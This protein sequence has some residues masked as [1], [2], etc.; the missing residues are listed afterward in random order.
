MLGV[1]TLGQHRIPIRSCRLDDGLRGERSIS[2][3]YTVLTDFSVAV[4]RLRVPYPLPSEFVTCQ[5]PPPGSGMSIDAGATNVV[6]AEIPC[7]RA[8]TKAN[9]LKADPV[10]LPDPP[11]PVARFTR[12]AASFAQYVR[13]PSTDHR[14]DVAGSR[15]EDGHGCIGIARIREDAR[16]R[17]LR[18][19]L[20]AGSSVVVIRKPP[21]NNSR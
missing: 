2:C 1:A 16:H 17:V 20:D 6:S 14:S 8:V 9:A 10:C 3:A 11:A 21:V 12:P 18:G 13:H 15:I 7:S 19:G 5:Y 4:R